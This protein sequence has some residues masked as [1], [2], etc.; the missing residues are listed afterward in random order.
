MNL[1]LH[2]ARRYLFSKK[3]HNAIHLISLVSVLGVAVASLA[4]VCVLSAFN[5]FQDL[6]ST[7]YSRFDPEIKITAVHGKSFQADSPAFEAVKTHG[8]VALLTE[9]LEENCLARYKDSQTSVI[10]KGVSES[11]AGMS[12][13]DE[14]V[15]AGSFRLEDEGIPM[16]SI[17]AGVASILATG[18]SMIDP[19]TL[20][21]PRRNGSVSLVDPS[22]AFLTRRIALTAAFCIGQ[23]EY[24]DRYVLTPI[25]FARD[26]FGFA[27][28]EV[29]SIELKLKDSRQLQRTKADIRQWLGADFQVLD[30]QEQKAEFFH[31]TR[32]E[33]AVTYLMLSFILLIA[34]FNVIG[35]LS[36]LILE[37]KNDA[38]ILTFLGADT[39]TVRRIFLYEGWMIAGA[40][41]LLGIV[42]GTL[43]CLAQQRFG[44]VRLGGGGSF[45]VDAY[46]VVIRP[47][48]LAL[49]L[50]T[51]LAVSI[52]SVWWPVHHAFSR[53][54]EAA[55]NKGTDTFQ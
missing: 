55:E 9:C 10:V 48:D 38:G 43:L 28:G 50:V 18:Y 40:G 42:L 24:D 30:L 33:K 25:A 29:T 22:S 3:S 7:L 14:T 35:S 46:P 1:P 4:M 44:L 49:V 2:I 8:N 11:F 23:P 17:G 31:V 6:L 15:F 47:A 53:Q 19:I 20:Y 13:I 54:D 5:G 45:I 21:A 16:A 34:L 39:K 12:G 32:M 27:P 36:M 52:P 51:V 37:K 26:L 41:G